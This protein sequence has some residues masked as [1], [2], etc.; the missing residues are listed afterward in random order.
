MT[1]DPTTSI[2]TRPEVESFLHKHWDNFASKRL[3]AH[4]DS[5]A[6]NSFMFGSSSKRVEPG[7]LVLLRR[8]REYMNESTRITAQLSNLEV[9]FVGTDAAVAAYN[10]QFDAEKR[11]VADAAGQKTSEE[12][13]LNGRVTH[14]IVRDENGN[15]KILHE[16]ISR[17]TAER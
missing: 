13:L 5:F 2:L 10:L 3:R 14:V 16:H 1:P 11:I 17:P 15:L 12:H 6:P 9:E 8:Q 7:R 4:E